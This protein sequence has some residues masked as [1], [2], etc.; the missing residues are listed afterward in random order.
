MRIL[1]RIAKNN[2]SVKLSNIKTINNLVEIIKKT[3]HNG[4]SLNTV[5]WH[6][7]KALWSFKA[8][9]NLL[10][11]TNIKNYT[12]FITQFKKLKLSLVIKKVIQGIYTDIS[13]DGVIIYNTGDNITPLAR[14]IGQ[15]IRTNGNIISRVVDQWK[16]N[17]QERTTNNQSEQINN[18]QTKGVEKQQINNISNAG[19]LTDNVFAKAIFKYDNSGEFFIY[20]NGKFKI[21]DSVN[22]A[23]P[24]EDS[25]KK[26]LNLLHETEIGTRI[27]IKYWAYGMKYP[28]NT[29]FVVKE[30]GLGVSGYQA[31]KNAASANK[32]YFVQNKSGDKLQAQRMA[33]RIM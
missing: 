15:Y 33:K 5:N 23:Y 10:N 11:D 25:F 1:Q 6:I 3:H 27:P 28:D 19:D 2:K 8:Y 13:Q 32:I 31:L 17:N 7:S 18:T 30:E 24:T 9:Q 16:R 21:C 29:L 14:N 4:Y 20:A 22:D 12:D 26:E